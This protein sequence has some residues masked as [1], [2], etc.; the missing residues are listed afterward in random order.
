MA[1]GGTTK[2]MLVLLVV[3]AVCAA[4]AWKAETQA[5]ALEDKLAQAEQ[6]LRDN[7]DKAGQVDVNAPSHA[8]IRTLD[9]APRHAPASQKARIIR[10]AEGQN[11][12][13]G[14][15]ELEAGAG[16]PEH[17]DP[18]EEYIIVLEGAGT[19]TIDGQASEIGPGS[20]VYMPA[21]ATVS[22]ANGDAPMRALQVF[23]GPESATKYDAWPVANDTP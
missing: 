4:A 2:L 5:I 23:A 3:A 15:L 6:D 14:Q 9:T 17:Q 16:V 18:T 21:Q 8:E 12:F 22:F 1:E 20:A 13:V 11:A 10:L 7:A 19:I